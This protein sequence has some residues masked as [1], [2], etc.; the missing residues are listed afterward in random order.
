MRNASPFLLLPILASSPPGEADVRALLPDAQGTAPIE[1]KLSDADRS[2]IDRAVVRTAGSG[3]PEARSPSAGIEL[4]RTK[5]KVEG[6]PTDLRVA[7]VP[8]RG[9]KGEFRVAVAADA[10]GVV[11]AAKALGDAGGAGSEKFLAQFVGP[12]ATARAAAAT[13]SPL[14]ALEEKRAAAK[15]DGPQAKRLRTLLALRAI[16]LENQAASDAIALLLERKQAAPAAP[17]ARKISEALARLAALGP[18]LPPLLEGKEVEAFVRFAEASRKASEELAQTLEKGDATRA[19]NLFAVTLQ[20]SCARCHGYDDHRHRK[21]LTNAF[22]KFREEAGVGPGWFLVGHDV[23]P[24]P[25]EEA[26]SQ[27]VAFAIKEGLLVLG[28][29]K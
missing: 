5:A 20:Q 23:L 3:S 13:G 28:K 2:S 12:W 10:S 16:M 26:A 22:E 9:P 29:A 19:G 8:A 21:P 18:D 11:Q 4:Y 7:I 27:A 15:G 6:E 1:A 24:A 17:H 25:G 14:T